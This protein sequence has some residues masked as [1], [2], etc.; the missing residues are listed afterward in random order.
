MAR[1]V[2]RTVHLAGIGFVALF[3]AMD[4]HCPLTIWEYNLRLQYDP[5][6]IYPGSFIVNWVERLVYPSVPPLVITIGTIF[7]G[8]FTI[9]AYLLCPPKKIKN[10]FFWPKT[11]KHN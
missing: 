3:A 4:K 10:L 9:A 7:I 8:L 11:E 2:F 1:W 6:M 5:D